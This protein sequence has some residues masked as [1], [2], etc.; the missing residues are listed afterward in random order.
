MA[1]QPIA[2]ART[3]Q[4]SAAHLVF[5]AKLHLIERRLECPATRHSGRKVC[6]G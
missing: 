3:A 4:Q 5:L 1:M 2:A 6:M